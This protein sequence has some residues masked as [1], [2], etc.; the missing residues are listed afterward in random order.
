M[1]TWE[2]DGISVS[3]G[4]SQVRSP[5][6]LVGSVHVQEIPV[7]EGIVLIG[8]SQRCCV[9]HFFF[10]HV[11]QGNGPLVCPAI[12]YLDQT[13]IH[14]IEKQGLESLIATD[15]GQSDVDQRP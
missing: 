12:V 8:S 14:I 1:L 15:E 5:G 4:T 11:S 2:V 10:L 7:N 13:L 6:N 3:N 9:M